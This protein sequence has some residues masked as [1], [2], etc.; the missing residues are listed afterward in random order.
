MP[1]EFGS[2][3]A[4]RIRELREAKGLSVRELARRSGI[5]P[6]SVSR[7]ERAINEV[8]LTNLQRICAGLGVTVVGFFD[9]IQQPRPPSFLVPE[10]RRAAELV[11]ALPEHRRRDV[12]QALELLLVGT[13]L[14]SAAT[15]RRR[16]R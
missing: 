10:A 4:R 14:P 7:S 11:D 1:S 5:A 8:S 9:F 16:R 6:E 13:D 12:L 3:V 15:H 2:Q